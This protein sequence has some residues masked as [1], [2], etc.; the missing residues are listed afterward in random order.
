MIHLID[1][2]LDL[3]ADLV[4]SIL[5]FEEYSLLAMALTEAGLVDAVRGFTK[6]TIF[7]PNNDAFKAIGLKNE[8]DIKS[9][10]KDEL[11]SILLY[12]VLDNT[13]YS[14]Q[15]TN[16]AVNTL[17]EDNPIFFSL[18][19]NG[20]FVNGTVKVT[21][22][23]FY[24]TNGTI[25]AIDKVLIPAEGSITDIVV[26]SEEDG[27]FTLLLRAIGRVEG[28]A[29]ALA[30]AKD[31]Y[32]TVFAPTD[33]AFRAAGLTEEAIAEADESYLESVLLY[34]VLPSA[35]FSTDIKAGSTKTLLEG[36]NLNISTTGGVKVNDSN[37]TKTNILATNGVIHVIDKV[38]IPNLK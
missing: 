25:H 23:D 5:D 16:G 37:I 20:V 4:E 7:A 36:Q 34:H 24:T 18:T 15:L 32:M 26:A 30:T 6:G 1:V 12:H 29:D 17:V 19:N 28:L 13:V 35:V 3:P 27:E 8:A 2:A 14:N 11:T 10:P 22:T 9:Y 31:G 33:A 21:D 38:L